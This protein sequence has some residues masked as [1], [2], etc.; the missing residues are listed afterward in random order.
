M[1]QG[2]RNTTVN[3]KYSIDTREAMDVLGRMRRELDEIQRAAQTS[4]GGQRRQQSGSIDGNSPAA[5]NARQRSDKRVADAINQEAS[6]DARQRTEL[7]RRRS[8]AAHLRL[9]NARRAEREL[10][11]QRERSIKQQQR[12]DLA[13]YRDAEREE[14]RQA[15]RRRQ[16]QRRMDTDYAWM[17][18]Q[19][20]R[21][22]RKQQLQE[23]RQ[24]AK[25]ERDVRKRQLQDE[26]E[27]RRRHLD[28]LAKRFG[29]RRWQGTHRDVPQDLLPLD[30]TERERTQF[31]SKVKRIRERKLRRQ[32]QDEEFAARQQSKKDSGL[33]LSIVRRLYLSRQLMSPS[34]TGIGSYAFA[35]MGRAGLIAAATIGAA[36]LGLEG[37][38]WHTQHLNRLR[39]VSMGE[40]QR[41]RLNWEEIPLAGRA[42][43]TIRENRDARTG[44]TE[45][46]RQHGERMEIEAS[47]NELFY[48]Q[49][50]QLRGANRS[51]RNW[52]TRRRILG[53]ARIIDDPTFDRS[54]YGGEVGHGMYQVRRPHLE[55]QI[56]AG[57]EV[58][59]AKDALNEA[60]DQERDIARQIA[61]VRGERG[62][63]QQR[64]DRSEYVEG[65]DSGSLRRLEAQ[66]QMDLEQQ[67]NL[68]RELLQ[69]EEQRQR[70][71][72]NTLQAAQAHTEAMQQQRQVSINLARDELAMASGRRESMA[73]HSLSIGTMGVMDRRLGIAAMTQAVNRG[74]E[75]LMP[76]QRQSALAFGGP[77]AQHMAREFGEQTPEMRQFRALEQREL[78]RRGI[79]L[80]STLREA[81]QMERSAQRRVSELEL[82]DRRQ[83]SDEMSRATRDLVKTMV[84]AFSE[85]INDMIVKIRAGQLAGVAASR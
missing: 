76:H 32:E 63:L 55:A 1:S 21:R 36:K 59:A 12:E 15:N 75:S 7:G 41:R 69:L 2:Q 73:A 60:R 74:W 33:D 29:E 18:A 34:A 85:S 43:R 82:F 66:R 68:G 79:I 81:E 57:R 70:A 84:M 62:R 38:D 72:A 8:R 71:Q 78:R 56:E 13:E 42:F 11:R 53:E 30:M 3:L 65:L 9:E 17:D 58:Q 40:A 77:L 25:N 26:R 14:K 80:P 49:S 10:N 16:D 39:N 47:T 48:S 51:A 45:R 37:A 54:T 61:G 27:I 50:E 44:L 46:L 64:I 22:E 5:D 23:E 52:S 35:H 24:H 19:E 20:R 28:D 31:D 4:L 67:V 6:D 83:V